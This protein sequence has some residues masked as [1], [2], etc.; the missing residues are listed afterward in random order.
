VNQATGQRV[1]ALSK[2]A[3][4]DLTAKPAELPATTPWD[5]LKLREAPRFEWIDDQGAVRSLLY[6]GE[7]YA[8][9]PTRVFA[10]ATR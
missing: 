4:L 7:P 10:W 3:E 2:P 1:S 8:G 6:D 9:K 5:L